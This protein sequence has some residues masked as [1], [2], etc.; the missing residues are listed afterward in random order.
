MAEVALVYS[1]HSTQELV[2]EALS[3]SSEWQT[4]DGLVAI[5][6]EAGCWEVDFE[7]RAILNT[8][9]ARIRKVVSKFK[10][11]DGFPLFPSITLVDDDGKKRRVYKQELLFDVE[12]YMVV[13]DCHARLSNHHREMAEGYVKRCERKHQ[14]QLSLWDLG[15]IVDEQ[16][17]DE[18]TDTSSGSPGKPR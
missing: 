16:L 3:S 9:K 11:K 7:Q 14:V 18:W 17:D 13:V 10:D 6:D 8:K 2:K 15:E 5:C 12:D 1:L 4:I